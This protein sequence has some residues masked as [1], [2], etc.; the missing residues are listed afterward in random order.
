MALPGSSREERTAVSSHSRW[1]FVVRWT[2]AVSVSMVVVG[3]VEYQIATAQL[4]ERSIEAALAAYTAYIPALEGALQEHSTGV[5][6]QQSIEH[7]LDEINEAPATL[8]VTLFDAGG[9]PVAGDAPD[10]TNK[11][12]ASVVATGQ[13]TA[14]EESDPGELGADRYEFLLPVESPRGPLVLEVDQDGAAIGGMLA[15]LRFRKLLGLGLGVLVAV[16]LSYLLGG[17]TLHMRQRHAERSA[18]TDAL[19]G[20]AGRRPFRPA[21]TR[22][23]ATPGTAATALALVDLDDFKQVNDRLGHTYGDRVLVALADSFDSLRASDTAFRLGGDEFAVVLPDVGDEQADEVLERVRRSFALHAPQITFSCG[24]ASADPR[25]DIG[26]QELWERADAALYEAKHRGRNQTATFSTIATHQAISVEKLDAVSVLLADDSGLSVVFQPIWDLAS[27][28]VLGH[29]ALLRLPAG[30]P[31]DGPQE[32]FALAQRLGIAAELDERAR[33][34]IFR[35]VGRRDWQGLLF[36]NVHPDSLARLDVDVLSADVRR[37]G[38]SPSDV[39]LEVTEH[40]G[41][42]RPE[43]IRM[44]KR[45]QSRGFRLA[46]DDLGQGNAGLRALTHVRFDVVKLDRQVIARLGI[47]PAADATVAAAITFIQQVGGWVIAEGVEDADMLDA[48]LGNGRRQA[49]PAPAMA[50]QGY[51]L[52]RPAPAPTAI[53]TRLAVLGADHDDVTS[54]PYEQLPWPGDTTP[55]L[56]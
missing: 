13:A 36:V 26:V 7:E 9:S 49:F 12:V 41:L 32:A 24:I 23:L 6:R 45:A 1:R 4:R 43:P 28:R 48:I 44:L 27:R 14:S 37:V 56:D 2:I 51:L 46:L 31:V 21:L 15:D 42:D 3:L 17:R 40:T 29:E 8:K 39:V 20:L 33:Q 55:V 34:E 16:P 47:D 52:G 38:L 35:S 19:T 18:A 50:G 53:D 25:T 10:G 54:P 30:T 11:D 22:A 5:E